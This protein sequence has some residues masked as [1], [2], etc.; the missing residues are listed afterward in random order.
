MKTHIILLTFR[1]YALVL[2]RVNEAKAWG[3][4]IY[5]YVEPSPRASLLIELCWACMLFIQ[6]TMWWVGTAC[7]GST[8]K[9]PVHGD[10]AV[11]YV[12]AAI[13]IEVRPLWCRPYADSFLYD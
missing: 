8:L 6:F 4:S 13:A 7:A 3:T 10:P 12:I 11:G 5:S 1:L 9:P 2:L